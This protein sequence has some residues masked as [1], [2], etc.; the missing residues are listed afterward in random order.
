LVK[1]MSDQANK[2]AESHSAYLSEVKYVRFKA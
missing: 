2:N 1:E